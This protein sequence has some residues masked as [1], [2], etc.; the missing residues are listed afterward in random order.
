MSLKG[1]LETVT[2]AG[3]LQLLCNE[4]KTGLLRVRNSEGDFQIIINEGN[5]VYAIESKKEARLGELLVRDRIVSEATISNSLAEAKKKKQAFGKIL[6]DQ[7]HIQKETLHKYIYMQV[8]E[9]LFTHERAGV[10]ITFVLPRARPTETTAHVELLGLQR[11]DDTPSESRV[12][13]SEA[14]SAR[15]VYEL[16]FPGPDR[17]R[18][19]FVE[20]EALN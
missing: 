14:A 8:E 19:E 15:P 9:I 11:P 4:Q 10:D 13:P 1:N 3:V 6:V 17:P 16:L 7:G 5:I 2:L 18:M 12:P 20:I